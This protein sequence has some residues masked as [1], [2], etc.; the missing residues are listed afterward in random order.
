MT[1][2][3]GNRIQELRVELDLNIEQM[4]QLLNVSSRTI[5]R[6]EKEGVNMKGNSAGKQNLQ[7]LVDVM[8]KDVTREELLSTLSSFRGAGIT[9]GIPLISSVLDTMSLISSGGGLYLG[10]KILTMLRNVIEKQSNK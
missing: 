3:T 10:E 4:A 1:N 6:W 9:I 5:Q 2:I 8:E 7:D